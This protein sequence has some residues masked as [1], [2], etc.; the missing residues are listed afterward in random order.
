MTDMQIYE[1]L[2]KIDNG[3]KPNYYEKRELVSVNELSWSGISHIPN[4]IGLLV[5]L[6]NLYLTSN[7]ILTDISPLSGLKCLT[8][9]DLSWSKKGHMDFSGLSGLKGLKSLNISQCYT[10]KDI[11]ALSVLTGLIDLNLSGCVNL[12]DISGLSGLI[13]LTYLNLSLCASLSDISALSGL[14]GL[15]SL[16]LSKCY[17]LKKISALFGLK[18]LTNIDLSECENLSDISELSCL[19]GLKSLNLSTCKKIADISAL[20]DLKGLKSLNLSKCKKVSDLSALSNLKGLK[21]LNI[22][23]CSKVKDISALSGLTGLTNLDLSR[24]HISSI[25]ESLV[26]LG[27]DFHSSPDTSN[28][29][30]YINKI[31]LDDQ[32]IEIFH[33]GRKAILEYF[34]SQ[35]FGSSPINECK[36]VFLGDGGAGKTLMIDRLMHDGKKSKDFTGKTTPGVSISAK[37]FQIEG[38]EIELHFWDFGGQEIMHSMHRLFLTNRTLYVV[39]ANAREN[40]ANVQAWY[41]IRNI[42][43]FANGAPILLVINQKDQCP[44]VSVNRNGLENEYP[45]LKDVKIISALKDSP[46]EFNR[47]IRGSIC[48]IVSGMDSVHT[49]FAQTWLSLMNNLQRMDEDYITSDVFYGMCRDNKIEASNSILDEIINWYQDLGVCFYS[50]KNPFSE[51]YMVLKPRWLL[52]AL[53]ILVFNGRQYA[54]NGVICEKDIYK[55]ILASE[56]DKKVRK[57][58]N[59]IKYEPFQVRYI[60]D[61]LQNFELLYRL[62]KVKYQAGEHYFIPMLCDENE[63][64]TIGAYESDEEAVHVSFR[65]AYL[66]DNIL[67]RLMVRRGDELNLEMVWRTG[68]VFEQKNFKWYALVRIKD[69]VLDVYVKAGNQD[70]APASVYLDMIRES[71]HLINGIYGITSEEFLSYWQ[72]GQ[73]DCFDYETLMGSKE[74]GLSEIYSKVFKRRISINEIL[75]IIRKP[76]DSI[77]KDVIEII[78]SALVDISNRCVDFEGKG[79]EEITRDVEA[80]IKQILN[81]RYQIQIAREYTLGHAKKKIGETDLYFYRHEK[82]KLENLYILENK[83]MHSFDFKKQYEQLIG[84]LNPSFK[85]GITLSINR[86]LRW[87]EAFDKIEGELRVLKDEGKEFAPININREMTVNRTVYIKSEHIVSETSKPMTIYHLVLQISDKV[88]RESARKAR[89]R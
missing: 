59:D 44:G 42:K 21:S 46:D 53:Y 63:P 86:N 68:A 65:Y 70:I 71:V 52:N 41:W 69:N 10:L 27:L 35:K 76:Q 7:E 74:S 12:I 8:N 18:K 73:E 29:G 36:V 40:N 43:S 5:S 15:K 39:V 3:Y 77:T 58:W 50:R 30:I 47:E 60:I 34:K 1:L 4:C 72:Y 37:S 22:S 89:E 54:K 62:E 13:N 78:L 57:V 80:A 25:P 64:K 24:L 66:P 20:S 51:Q 56:S 2:V 32:P 14:K 83:N 28:S 26:E 49:P 48:S 67:H 9:L 16:N 82:G 61:V 85:A 6:T 17:Q 79:E 45:A 19:K 55:L 75:G 23:E 87:E 11:G 33:H 84:Y 88:R 81:D 38:E 31:K